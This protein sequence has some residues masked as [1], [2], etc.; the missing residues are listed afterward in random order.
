MNGDL[1]RMSIAI[2]ENSSTGAAHKDGI[3]Y[4]KKSDRQMH[5]RFSIG[6]DS[7]VGTQLLRGHSQTRFQRCLHERFLGANA[8]IGRSGRHARIRLQ[9][10]IA[11]QHPELTQD[12]RT[13]DQGKQ[14][15][16]E[17]HFL[18]RRS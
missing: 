8:H 12:G 17:R 16:S 15:R 7:R 3:F 6:I 1:F 4:C 13:S 9:N 5:E 18:Q 14:N 10:T 2:S 11:E